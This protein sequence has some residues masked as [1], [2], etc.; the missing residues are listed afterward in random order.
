MTLMNWH[1]MLADVSAPATATTPAATQTVMQP[2]PVGGNIMQIGVI[3]MMVVLFY[4]LMIRPQNKKAKEH[5]KLLSTLKPGDKI[6]TGSGFVGV[7]VGIKENRVTI[8]S[9]ESKLEVLK[10]AIT[11]VTERGGSSGNESNS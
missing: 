7:V 8:R 10:S 2:N 5:A 6:L 11:E 1:L 9:A 4:V 3:V